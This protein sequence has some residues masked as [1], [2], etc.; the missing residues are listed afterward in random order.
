MPK[1]IYFTNN[2]YRVL[3]QRLL[4]YK[5]LCTYAHLRN[6][7]A[8]SCHYVDKMI[9]VSDCLAATSA[10]SRQRAGESRD[11]WLEWSGPPTLAY[12]Y[13]LSNSYK[14]PK[15]IECQSI[16]WR[17]CPCAALTLT[18]ANGGYCGQTANSWSNK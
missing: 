9:N 4:Q 18:K 12:I 10:E 13:L 8:L 3:C 7:S 5:P 15:S 16:L 14:S 1:I 2:S 6:A 11:R 17:C